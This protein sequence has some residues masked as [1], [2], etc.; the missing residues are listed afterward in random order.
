ML[1]NRNKAIL[2]PLKFSLLIM[3]FTLLVFLLGPIQWIKKWDFATFAVIGLLIAYFSAFSLGYNFR[4]K[5]REKDSIK[6]HENQKKDGYTVKMLRILRITIYINLFLTIANAYIY[7]G[8][9]SLPELWNKM[10]QG[11]LSPSEVYYSKDASS[12]ADSIIVW[13]MFIYSP[14][15]DVTK[16][17]ALYAYKKLSTGLKVCYILTLLIEIMR[18]LGV[19]TNKGLFDIVILFIFFYLLIRMNYFGR[20]SEH[21]LQTKK[22]IRRILLVVVIGT[23]L[24]FS[25]FGMAISSRVDGAY[26]ESYFNVFPYNIMPEGLRFFSEK[27]DSYLTQGYSNLIEMVRNGEWK[28]TFGVGNS[29]FLMDVVNRVFKIDLTG[30]TYPYQLEA[31]GVDPLAAWH[32][33]YAWFASDISFIGVI[34]LMFMVGF[35]MCGLAKDVIDKADPVS[36]T[37]LYLV[38]LSVVNASCTNYVIAYSNGF[39]SFWTLFVV[40]LLRKNHVHFK[41]GSF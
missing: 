38:L 14:L 8:V 28:W 6:I 9:S 39:I 37:L 35:Y 11:L 4:L 19:G 20:E 25:F 24:F 40:R 16:V 13:L 41:L 21:N 26:T 33:A 22:Q 18:W 5:V 12:R 23:V 32:T 17:Y 31:F 27:F 34:F 36:M 15:M 30:R 1:T 2:M 7:V 29:R 10:M 3:Y